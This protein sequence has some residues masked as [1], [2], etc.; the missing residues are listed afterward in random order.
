MKFLSF[1]IIASA[2][3]SAIACGRV[4]V[5]DAH[6]G[7][8][9]D[10]GNSVG[11]KGGAASGTGGV[12][13]VGGVGGAGSGGARSACPSTVLSTAPLQC[14]QDWTHA[15]KAY[16]KTCKAS[17]GGYQATC[18]SYDTIVYSDGASDIWCF[19][20]TGTGNLSGSFAHGAKNAGVCQSFDLDFAMPDT[21]GCT[22]VSGTD[23][24]P[25]AGP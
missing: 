16:P 1:P 21:S 12:G 4:G 18:S 7:G 19:Y 25:D 8:T 13:G 15:K 5:N 10:G 22:S 24:G 17:R 23:C 20:G 6:P 3:C 11:G 9:T 2:L 14:L